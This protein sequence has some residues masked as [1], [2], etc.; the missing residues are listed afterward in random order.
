VTDRYD[1]VIVGTGSGNS[2]LDERFDDWRVAIVERGVFGGTC[3][4]RG[5]I[6]TKMLVLPAEM[7]HS[8][9]HAER[10]GVDLRLDGVRWR[11]IRDRVF[12]RIDPIAASGEDY[13]RSQP[14]VTLLR[15]DAHFSGDKE[16]TVVPE[17]GPPTVLSADRFVLAVGSRPVTIDVP[18]LGGFGFHTSDT[19]M[20]IDDLPDRM[21]II[22]SGFVA[23]E[24]GH[25][26]DA[27][28]CHV[29]IVT[30]GPGLLT[31]LDDD[32]AA[33]VSDDMGRR[34]RLHRHSVVRGVSEERGAA[35]VAIE[36]K[37]GRMRKVET[38]LI[39]VAAGRIPNGDQIDVDRTGL[40]LDEAGFIA[41]DVTLETRVPGIF[42][43]GDA[44]TTLMLKHVANHE[45]RVVQ[46]N[47]LHPAS[48]RR[49]N[50][51]WV[52]AA[53]FGHPQVGT[54][55]LS[56]A[57]AIAAG[58]DVVVVTRFYR[59]TAYGWALENEHDF[60][61]LVADRRSGSLLGAH[62]VG[63]QAP[64]LLQQIVE[65]LAN[66]L[67]VQQMAREQMYPHPALSEVVEQALLELLERLG[68]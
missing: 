34:V 39:L 14:N 50:E 7:A 43:L 40:R 29:E 49:I 10:L 20:R 68:S 45:A 52:P 59:D 13:R 38:D 18:G 19:V 48:P 4:N 25:V 67:S 2:I 37:T 41:T 21:L 28:G 36:D 15:G 46:H 31:H 42:A 47:L 26:F 11:E 6:P 56:E 53:V 24:L 63:P 66:G 30:R 5:C 54:V 27:F 8:V 65:G 64:T 58:H 3:L 12:G 35:L 60:C 22:G 62:I 55:G 1:L 33:R 51:T 32:V 57:E 9:G 23:T 16:L 61:K 17:V 44:R